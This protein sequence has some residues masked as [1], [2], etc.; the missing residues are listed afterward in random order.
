V[1]QNP[2]F[3]NHQQAEGNAKENERSIINGCESAI[4]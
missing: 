1:T 2:N 3:A 4:L